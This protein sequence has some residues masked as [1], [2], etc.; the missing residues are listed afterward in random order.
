MKETKNGFFD[1]KKCK[2]CGKEFIPAPFHKYKEGSKYYCSW[3]CYNH[4]KDE[5][6]VQKMNISD[7]EATAY[8]SD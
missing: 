1:T 2:K 4:R 7:K 8:E 5:L 3:T 6:G